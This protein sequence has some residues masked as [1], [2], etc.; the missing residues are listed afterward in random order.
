MNEPWA[1]EH[2]VD[3]ELARA[4]IEDQF[5]EL[6]P[7]KVEPFGVGWDN[8]AYLVNTKWVFRFPRRSIAAPLIER[9]LALLPAIA[10]RVTLPIPVPRFAGRPEE[11]FAWPFAGYR[12]LEGRTASRLSHDLRGR[13]A[14]PLGRFLAALHA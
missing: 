4:L 8:T 14:E 9:E 11:R 7:A 3:V 13:A 12:V 2:V 6:V 1:A 5:P 10:P